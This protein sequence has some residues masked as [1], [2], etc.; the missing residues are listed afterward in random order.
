[1][2]CKIFYELGIQFIIVV[3]SF[4]IGFL[5]AKFF[6]NYSTNNRSCNQISMIGKKD[7]I[8]KS[9]IIVQ[10]DESLYLKEQDKK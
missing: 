7:A 10:D 1:M 4:F 3:L 9:R 2:E 8:R 5:T 6:S